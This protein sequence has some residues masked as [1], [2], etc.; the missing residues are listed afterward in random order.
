MDVLSGFKLSKSGGERVMECGV[1]LLDLGTGAHRVHTNYNS[2]AFSLEPWLSPI[3]RTS[4]DMATSLY[5]ITPS[6]RTGRI[7]WLIRGDDAK[8]A[9][10]AVAATR[11]S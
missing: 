7:E 6:I 10:S 5:R 3:Y 8:L 2:L 9:S 11:T 4:E 1:E